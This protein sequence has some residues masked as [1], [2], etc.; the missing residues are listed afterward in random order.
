MTAGLVKVFARDQFDV[1][2]LALAFVINGFGNRRI[3]ARNR[4]SGEIIFDSIC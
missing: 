4:Y 2:L 3:T 1:F